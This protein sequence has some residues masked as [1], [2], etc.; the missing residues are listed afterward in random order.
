MLVSEELTK[1]K[2][3][4]KCHQDMVWIQVTFP[5]LGSSST[6]THYDVR[7]WSSCQSHH[8]HDQEQSEQELLGDHGHHAPGAP[9][10]GRGQCHVKE[11]GGV[12]RGSTVSCHKLP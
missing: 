3:R 4:G 2:H 5:S 1:T 9:H 11:A 10:H 12:G 7:W 8:H 6:D